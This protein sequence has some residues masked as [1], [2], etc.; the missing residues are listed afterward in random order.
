VVSV[1]VI[2]L[3]QNRLTSMTA[4]WAGATG[5]VIAPAHEAFSGPSSLGKSG[6][7]PAVPVEFLLR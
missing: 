1:A 2:E 4:R 5:P 3:S 6:P 7:A